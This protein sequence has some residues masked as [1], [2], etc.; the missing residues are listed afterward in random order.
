MTVGQTGYVTAGDRRDPTVTYRDPEE[1]GAQRGIHS[2]VT[3]S[4]HPV[5]AADGAA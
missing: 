3:L 2:Q 4:H 1:N 5:S